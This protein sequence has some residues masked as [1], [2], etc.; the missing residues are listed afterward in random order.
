MNSNKRYLQE[1]LARLFG[2]KIRSGQWLPESKIPAIRQ[3]A[4]EY[5]VSPGS[6]AGAIK[7]LAEKN[8]I[9][10]RRGSGS[11]VTLPDFWHEDFSAELQNTDPLLEKG[12]IPEPVLHFL[13]HLDSVDSSAN[14]LGMELINFYTSI[15]CLM[16]EETEA[17]KWRLRIGNAAK[18]KELLDNVTLENTRGIIY[19]PDSCHSTDLRWPELKFPKVLFSIGEKSLMSNYVTPDNYQG[20][21]LAASYMLKRVFRQIIVTSANVDEQYFGYK[22]FR[23]RI[24]GFVD[25]CR[26]TNAPE[27]EIVRLRELRELPNIFEPILALPLKERPGVIFLGDCFLINQ[28]EKAF[29]QYYPNFCFGKDVEI[30]AFMD[31]QE[32]NNRCYASISFSKRQMCR[33]VVDLVR[34]AALHPADTPIRVKIPMKLR[35]AE[36]KD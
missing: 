16:Q 8:L 33:E 17:V 2:E 5:K 19:M 36:N 23:E 27:P 15:I 14:L 21:C 10:I 4:C 18:I 29:A 6:V 12:D 26:L 32:H 34:R 1:R 9:V 7:I 22:P 24:S 35:F 28:V 13:F 25:F 20:G 11:Y 3:L 31:Y 30:L